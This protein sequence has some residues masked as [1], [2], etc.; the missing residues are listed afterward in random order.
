MT[1]PVPQSTTLSVTRPPIRLTQFGL[2]N[3]YL[4]PEADGLTLIDAGMPG[5][6]RRV[7]ST[8]KR[9]GLPLKR[10]ALTHAHDDHIGAIDAL[11]AAVPELELLVGEHDAALLA[12][13]GIK[14]APTR[15]LRG[16][17][18]VGSLTVFDTPGHSAGHVAYLDG[19][20]GTLYS[21]DTFV[22]VPNLHVASV[23]NTVFPLPTLGTY[24]LAQTTV[25]ARAMLD[26]PIRFLATGH[27]RVV[28]DPLPAMRRAVADAESGRE[29]SAFARAVAGAVG[30]MTGM[31]SA[32]GVAGKNA[33]LGTPR[34]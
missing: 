24:D 26:I 33:I 32:A 4:V 10:L 31:G 19:R 16:G 8:A 5:M 25:S 29:P 34:N 3:A 23:L 27:G 30:R 14:T 2:I 17:D 12:G 6:E 15:L 11:K 28:Q 18:R 22:N 13:R 21:G 1:S 7:L 9:L 20:D